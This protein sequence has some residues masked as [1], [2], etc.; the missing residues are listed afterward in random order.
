M[1]RKS[2]WATLLCL[3]AVAVLTL[4]AVPAHAQEPTVAII[5]PFGV[6]DTATR[7]YIDVS[8]APGIQVPYGY[9][10]VGLFGLINYTRGIS[11]AIPQSLMVWYD[12]SKNGASLTAIAPPGDRMYWDIVV[13]I[14]P[15]EYGVQPPFNP[16][17]GAKASLRWWAAPLEVLAIGDYRADVRVEVK[18]ASVDLIGYEVGQQHPI[19]YRPPT[20]WGWATEFEVVAL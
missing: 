3:A 16:R 12:L 11:Q 18:H 4:A 1:R 14:D 19:I 9:T 2:V 15:A 8:A 6:F 13:L 17:I 5:D 20:S 7:T 10:F